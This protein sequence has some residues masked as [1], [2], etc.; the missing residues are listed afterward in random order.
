MTAGS[1]RVQDMGEFRSES[2]RWSEGRQPAAGRYELI[3]RFTRARDYVDVRLRV[4]GRAVGP[5]VSGYAPAVGVTGPV[6][7]GQVELRA[8]VNTVEVE[9]VGKDARAQGYSNGYL[10]GLDGFLVRR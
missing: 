2:A 8:G 6:S 1:L 3:G 10:V 4:N 5:L 7:F 9:I